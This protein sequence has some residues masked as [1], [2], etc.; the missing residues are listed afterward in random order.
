MSLTDSSGKMKPLSVLMDDMRGSMQGL[1]EEQQAYFVSTLFGKEA[2]A[3]MLSI[4]NATDEDY[5]KLTNSINNAT[6]AADRMEKEMMNN[7]KGDF[8]I[9]KSTTEA[10]GI[11]LYETFDTQLRGVTQKA[12]GY[13]SELIDATKGTD[14]IRKEMLAT[15]MSIHDVN[16]A[17][18]GMEFNPGGFEGLAKSLGGIVSNVLKDIA[19]VAPKVIELAV[20]IITSL[21]Q[22]ISDNLPQLIDSAI[23]I[24]ATLGQGLMTALPML[25]QLLF[26]G[27]TNVFNAIS[28]N[29]DAVV[30]G[31]GKFVVTMAELIIANLPTLLSAGIKMIVSLGKSI[32]GYLPQI[33]EI[34]PRLINDFANAL[35]SQVPTLLKGAWDLMSALAVG[36]V[37]AIPVIIKNLPQI[38]M[39]IIN[40]ITLFN[41]ASAGK[42]IIQGL[43]N[44]MSSLTGWLRANSGNII[45]SAGEGF[46]TL[47][48]SLPT[49]ARNIISSL[50]GG[51]KGNSGSILQ[52]AKSI[53]I[54]MIQIYIKML[55]KFAG[56]GIYI[57]KGIVNG[58]AKASVLLI[59]KM[60]ELAK[61]VLVS[62]P[63]RD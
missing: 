29:S 34:A 17:M 62:N 1:S 55:P 45:K 41:W 30:G 19:S 7:L 39:A 18:A 11:S 50:A 56:L 32:I 14:Q 3:G 44:G 23:Q 31:V 52:A 58:L 15:G 9:L 8:Q 61:S 28:D 59:S 40:V 22:G 27:L 21:I 38:I 46:L 10:L 12:T 63:R 20:S 49:I 48:K 4:I 54:K 42:S 57:I 37:K 47:I 13:I 36:L 24:V 5:Q 6:G 25:A 26:D 53:A 16:E 2:M 60:T 33:I 43:G 35:Y 51:L